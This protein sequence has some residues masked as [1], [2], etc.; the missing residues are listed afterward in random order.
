MRTFWGRLGRPIV[1]VVRRLAGEDEKRSIE[2]INRPAV[3]DAV[4][5]NPPAIFSN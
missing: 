5:L 4:P 2:A 1:L 3:P